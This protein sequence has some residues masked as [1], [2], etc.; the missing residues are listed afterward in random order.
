MKFDPVTLKKVLLKLI[1]D[2]HSIHQAGGGTVQLADIATAFGVTSSAIAQQVLSQ[3]G[4][5]VFRATNTNNG[6]VENCGEQMR[7]PIN[8]AEVVIPPV[9]AGTYISTADS[10]ILQMNSGQTIVGK[11]GF[12]SAP[13]ESMSANQQQASVR[14]GGLLGG[15]LSRTISLNDTDDSLVALAAR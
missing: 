2:V 13:L 8:I 9:I 11:K 1:A 12:L 15:L 7:L 4:D 5:M 3:R 6:V 14:V 10:L